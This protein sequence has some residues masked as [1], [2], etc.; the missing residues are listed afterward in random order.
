MFVYPFDSLCSLEGPQA[1]VEGS[2]VVEFAAP[3]GGGVFAAGLGVVAAVLVGTAGFMILPT[4]F[5]SFL[6]TSFAKL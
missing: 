2:V 1:L 6:L 4:V 5:S 3:G